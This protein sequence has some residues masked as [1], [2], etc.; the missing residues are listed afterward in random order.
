MQKGDSYQTLPSTVV[1]APAPAHPG[2][3]TRWIRTRL[4][5]S[6]VFIC[7][8]TR[9]IIHTWR[10]SKTAPA[11]DSQLVADPEFD[12]FTLTPSEDIKWTPCFSDF[13]CARLILPLDYLSPPAPGPTQPSR[14]RCYPPQIRRITRKFSSVIGPA[15]DILGFDPRGTGASTPSAQCFDSDSQHKIFGLQGRDDILNLSDGSVAMARSRESIIGQRCQAALGGNGKEEIGATVDEWGGGRFMSTAS[16]ATDM[17]KITEKLGQE[18]LQYWGFSYGSVLGQY[19]SA[20]YPDKVGRVIIDG[21][22]DAY[23]YRAGLW[24]SNL[25]D[26]DAVVDSFYTFCHQGGSVKCPLYELSVDQIKDRVDSIM[27]RLEADPIAL[28]FASTGPT[29]FTKH[30]FV[31]MLF[32]AT[33]K[34]TAQFS[35]I[36]KILVSAESSNTTAL[37]ELTTKLSFECTCKQDPAW[38][39]DTQA[40]YFIACGDAET[41]SFDPDAYRTFFEELYSVSP[42]AAPIWAVHIIQCSQWSIRPKWRYTGPLAA[43]NTAHPLLVI[44]P[45][46]DPVCPLSDAR[47]VHARYAG[48]G[49]L[50]QDSYGHCSIASPSICTAKHVRTYFENGT[51]PEEG[52]VCEVDELPFVGSVHSQVEAMSVEDR[53]LLDALKGL[54]DVVPMFGNI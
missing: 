44:S 33:Y 54:V 10:D 35:D 46:Y 16:V 48:A 37:A 38:L 36:A 1:S 50:V 42:F 21:V 14:F 43:N 27:D 25:A 34:P 23:N 30:D 49:L 3:Q 41:V 12:W 32:R 31:K 13:K 8:G 5:V 45:T 9:S 11:V 17:L 2:L 20:M 51:L 18:K 28:P 15:H 52:T 24:N 26:T 39:V 29:V 40:F 4:F 7:I 22:Y 47:K 6:F 19:F 53:E